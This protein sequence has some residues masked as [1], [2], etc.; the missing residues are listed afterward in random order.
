MEKRYIIISSLLACMVLFF[1]EQVIMVDYLVK[2][3]S[4]VVLF[5]VVPL[6]YIKH[7]KKASMTEVLNLRKIDK[8]NLKLGVV[9]GIIS[10]AIVL[11]T[12]YLVKDFM[13]LNGIVAEMEEKSKITPANFFLVGAYITF[14]NSFL[15]EFFFRGFIFLNLYELGSKKT[16]YIYSSVLF[17]VYH[18]AIFITWF[19]IW[20]LALALTGLILVGFIFS[21]LNTTSKNFLNSWIVH[22]LA[23][24]AIIIIG[25]RL[26]GMV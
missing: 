16:A 21:W 23:D 14:G 22:I 20:L 7:I 25:M 5:S 6:F 24:A 17:A 11:V 3:L 18:L 2:T 1:V 19:N 8:N 13:D 9:F 26:L 10:F 4:K 15:E 12:Y